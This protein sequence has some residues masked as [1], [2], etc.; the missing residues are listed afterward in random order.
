M[1]GW[2][3][4]GCGR[5]KT[6]QVRHTTTPTP[7]YLAAKELKKQSWRYHKK[8]MTWFQRHEEP[9]VRER[10][11]MAMVGLLVGSGAGGDRPSL[12]FFAWPS[13]IQFIPTHN[14]HPD[15]P[16]TQ[17]PTQVTTDEYE[18]GTYVYFDCESGWCTRIK[19]EFTFEYAYLESEEL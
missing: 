4:C 10:L 11:L 18:Q 19:Q 2:M 7:Q 6:A 8:Y 5:K 9:K 16:K 15:P 12:R 3:A 17:T 14:N 1:N 13:A